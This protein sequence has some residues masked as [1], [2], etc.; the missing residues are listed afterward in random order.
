MAR[1]GKFWLFCLFLLFFLI[2]IFISVFYSSFQFET[3]CR[4][5]DHH[6]STD[7]LVFD[8]IALNGHPLG[9]YPYPFS[10]DVKLMDK[11]WMS[12]GASMDD[13]EWSEYQ[14]RSN[15]HLRLCYATNRVLPNLN[16][17]EF[18]LVELLPAELTADL[19]LRPRIF[20]ARAVDPFEE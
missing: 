13:L 3:E 10:I 7:R 5:T 4:M 16:Q 8:I 18:E 19:D 15:G 6:R 2:V 17:W 11:F 12:L 14:R 1:H 20:T 9:D